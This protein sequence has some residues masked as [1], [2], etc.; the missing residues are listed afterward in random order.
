MGTFLEKQEGEVLDVPG[1][2]KSQDFCGSPWSRRPET[3]ML[4]SRNT[5][6]V[7][8]R[9]APTN[10]FPPTPNNRADAWA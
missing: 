8:V 6:P 2:G 10:R 5:G 1:L 9:S 4:A 7:C 3:R